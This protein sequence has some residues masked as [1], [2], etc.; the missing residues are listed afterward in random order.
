MKEKTWCPLS[1]RCGGCD[2]ANLPYSIE[3]KL[4][5]D[6][7]KKLFFYIDVPE[8]IPCR[9]V[10]HYRDKVQAVIGERNGRIVSGLYIKGTHHV[11]ELRDCRLEFEG[12]SSILASVRSL[13]KSFSLAPYDE[14]RRTGDLRHVLLRH[15]HNRNEVMVTL[16]FGTDR[17]RR[18]KEFACALVHK[19]PEIKTVAWQLNDEKTSM[20]LSDNDIRI[21]YGEGYIEDEISTL[22]FRITPSSF[23][24]INR[25]QT[26]VLYE[27]AMRMASLRGNERV[28]DA[29]SG[30]GTIA[31]IASQEADRVI[32]VEENSAAVEIAKENARLNGIENVDFVS[33]D[34]SLFCKEAAK[35]GVKFDAAFLDPPRSGCDERFLSSLIKMGPEK[36]VY[37]SCNP[38]T[39]ARDIRYLKNFGS[40]YVRRIQGVDM[41]PRTSHVESVA[42]LTKAPENDEATGRSFAVKGKHRDDRERKYGRRR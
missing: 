3:L 19:H 24:Q 36:I 15:A 42:L 12:A 9:S 29:Y 39:Q 13:M 21:L 7:L 5:R 16:V 32:A 10:E 14:D 26:E 1:S 30:T 28:L 40:Y 33:A 25:S 38:E 35:K 18:K 37:I 2:Y 41:F 34:A 27:T 17:F 6:Y 8:V 23:F 22:H 11:I 20:V 4:K 31:L